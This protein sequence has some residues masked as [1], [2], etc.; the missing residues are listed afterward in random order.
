MKTPLSPLN[1]LAAPSKCSVKLRS[2]VWE[3]LV[4]G[5]GSTY[6]ANYIVLSWYFHPLDFKLGYLS[7][8]LQCTMKFLPKSD[9]NEIFSLNLLHY[10]PH[11]PS[12]FFRVDVLLHRFL[13]NCKAFIWRHIFYLFFYPISD[14]FNLGLNIKKRLRIERQFFLF[15]ILYKMLFVVPHKKLNVTN[16]LSLRRK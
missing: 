16:F 9:D 2:S 6:T 12:S 8:S 10:R 15:L 13:C 4:Q 14:F 11:N 5:S 3:N 1:P 7:I